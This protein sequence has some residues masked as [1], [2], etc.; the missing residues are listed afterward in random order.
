MLGDAAGG[1]AA[2]WIFLAV[3]GG[4]LFSQSEF[5]GIC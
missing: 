3:T 5:L 1:L 4:L 2:N